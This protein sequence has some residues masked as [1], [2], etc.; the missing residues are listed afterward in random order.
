M[1]ET[2]RRTRIPCSMAH[3]NMIPNS[4]QSVVNDALPRISKSLLQ[5]PVEPNLSTKETHV[6]LLLP[7]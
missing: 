4:H 3:S 2:R 7:H 1:T 5:N 6:V